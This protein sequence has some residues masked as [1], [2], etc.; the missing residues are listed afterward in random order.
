MGRGGSFFGQPLSMNRFMASIRVQI[1]EVFP[2]HEPQGRARHSVRA[3]PR[4]VQVG[5]HGVTRPTIASRFRGPNRGF[6][7]AV[8]SLHEP[9]RRTPPWRG[10]SGAKVARTPNA[11]RQ[12]GRSVPRVS[13]WSAGGFSA[14]LG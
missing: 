2:P 12:S 9:E 3:A 7:R 13:V 6:S 4:S 5:A 11:S 1:L 8:E 14:A 10:E